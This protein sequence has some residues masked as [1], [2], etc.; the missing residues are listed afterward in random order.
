M[1]VFIKL[2]TK[3]FS[4]ELDI[5]TKVAFLLRQRCCAQSHVTVS[6]TYK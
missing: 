2:A 3:L 4:D 1:F 6:R 5:V